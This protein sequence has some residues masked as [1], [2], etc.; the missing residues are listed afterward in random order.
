MQSE[1]QTELA[2]LRQE[3]E[4]DDAAIPKCKRCGGTGEVPCIILAV[5]C[6][7]RVVK[8]RT[9]PTCGGL[10]V[11]STKGREAKR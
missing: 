7:N 9:C 5:A 1:N 11:K 2:E 6:G 10:G 3:I 8:T 4:N